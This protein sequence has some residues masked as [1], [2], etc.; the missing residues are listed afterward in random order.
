MTP[1][2]VARALARAHGLPWVAEFRDLW[3]DNPEYA[4]TTP[5]WRH[6][7]DRRCERALLAGCAGLLTASPLMS[8][9]L[10]AKYQREVATVLNGFDPAD[11]PTDLPPATN[12]GALRLVFTGALS[13]LGDDL[14]PL[15]E[16]LRLLG[17]EAERVKISCYG[18]RLELIRALQWDPQVGHCFEAHGPVPYH[19]SLRLQ[20]EADALLLPIWN[21]VYDHGVLHAKLYEYLGARR[22]VVI[23]GPREDL[24]ARMVVERQAGV[25]L[26]EPAQVAAHL[27]A[28]LAAKQAAGA[29]PAP[30]SRDLTDV[31]REHQANRLSAYFEQVLGEIDKR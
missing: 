8:Q 1:A 21:D 22:P 15:V 4:D 6:A 19:E 13:E 16:G 30:P 24:A 12:R 2:Y 7:L 17:P 11:Y 3:L 27:R 5:A 23:I 28:L 25:F 31:T 18:R 14:T 10:A 26:S 20:T 29:V 9:T